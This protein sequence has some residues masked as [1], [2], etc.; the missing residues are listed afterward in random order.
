MQRNV[1][2]LPGDFD[3]SPTGLGSDRTGDLYLGVVVPG[4][5]VLEHD[6]EDDAP[7]LQPHPPPVERVLGEAGEEGVR[8]AATMVGQRRLA[9]G[10]A[11]PVDEAAWACKAVD[12]GLGFPVNDVESEAAGG[13]FL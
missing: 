7:E 5:A 10:V 13:L 9:Q 8:V 6:A 11:G 12:D 3:V 2:V 1:G 4:F